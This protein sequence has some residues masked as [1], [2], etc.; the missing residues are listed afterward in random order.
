MARRSTGQVIERKRSRGAVYAL[1]FFAAGE[2]QYVTLGTAQ[3][4]WSRR[5]AEDELAATMASVRAGSW[6]PPPP[7]LPIE[8]EPTFHEFASDWY[9]ANEP[10]WAEE[11]RTNYRWQLSHHLLPHFKD[12][13]LRQITVAEVDH[14]REAK[15]REGRLSAGQINKTITRLGQILD[16][17]HERE[18]IDRNPV[19]V[20]PKRRKLKAQKPRPVYLD[21]AGQIAAVL[22]AASTLDAKLN[23]RTGGRRPFMATLIFAGLRIGEACALKRHHVNLPAGRIEVPGTKT[24]AA[25]RDVDLLP[26]LRDELGTYL[27]SRGE[28]GDRRHLGARKGTNGHQRRSDRPRARAAGPGLGATKPRRKAVN[29]ERARQDSNL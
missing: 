8:R 29:G 12:H 23:A 27:A 7:T 21:S 19:R 25:A 16:V 14:Y 9:T 13:L 26:V 15:Q 2:R 11:T 17:A 28:V 4:G 20:N 5:R 22:D 10:G 18:L 6:A 3:E 1:R 24:D